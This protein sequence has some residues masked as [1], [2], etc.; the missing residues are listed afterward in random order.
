MG[1]LEKEVPDILY[2]L[3]SY[4]HPCFHM[5]RINLKQRINNIDIAE[6]TSKEPEETSTNLQ[7]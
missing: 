6:Q 1:G 2:I 3:I 4:F 7:N 5:L